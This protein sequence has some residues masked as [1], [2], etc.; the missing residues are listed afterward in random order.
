MDADR[1]AKKRLVILKIQDGKIS[2]NSAVN[3]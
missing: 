3:P 1:N 2:F